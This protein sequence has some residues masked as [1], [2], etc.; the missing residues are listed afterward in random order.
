VAIHI[1]RQRPNLFGIEGQRSVLL[2]QIVKSSKK[3]NIV[4][5]GPENRR[6][7]S[8]LIV[9]ARN[10]SAVNATL[11]GPASLYSTVRSRPENPNN[12]DSPVIM[13]FLS[14]HTLAISFFMLSKNSPD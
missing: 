13:I 4:A 1:N 5:L 7:G 11:S 8:L 14:P 12:L 9:Y 3:D 2:P 6:E 10:S